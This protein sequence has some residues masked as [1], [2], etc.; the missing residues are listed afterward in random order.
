MNVVSAAKLNCQTR[1]FFSFSNA[2]PERI[3]ESLEMMASKTK[4]ATNHHSLSRLD[5]AINKE[6]VNNIKMHP[7]LWYTVKYT[8]KD[9]VFWNTISIEMGIQSEHK[10]MRWRER[11]KCD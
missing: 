2:F 1:Q 9:E 4:S 11:K 5:M 6:L 7:S 10:V 8:R 3:L